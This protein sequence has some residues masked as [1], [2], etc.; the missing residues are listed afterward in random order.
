MRAIVSVATGP[1]VRGLDRLTEWCAAHDTEY[2]TWRGRLPNGAPSHADVPY[3]FK[4]FAMNAAAVEATTLLWCDSCMIPIKPLDP[5]WEQIE[6][7]GYLVFNNGYSNYEWTA[8]SAYPDLFADVYRD[9]PAHFDKLDA[10]RNMNRNI[11][12]VVGGLI[13]LDLTQQIGKDF[14][15]EWYRLAKTRAFCGPWINSNYPHT[16]SP[17]PRSGWA[18]CGPPD[19]RGH[20]HDQSALS[21]I[22]WRLGCKLTEA[23]NLFSYAQLNVLPP[24][25]RTVIL[26]D[27]GYLIV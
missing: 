12:H 8:D 17:R 16:V 24:D 10:T 1:F 3:A 13:G 18:P 9:L 26:A 15:A 23:P 27:G 19:V 21:V 25:P 20:R 11:K 7:D 5:V 14:L 22:A 2:V 4:P 6:R